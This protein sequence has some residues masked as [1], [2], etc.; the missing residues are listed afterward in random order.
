MFKIAGV[1]PEKGRAKELIEA[2]ELMKQLRDRLAYFQ[3]E[4]ADMKKSISKGI[5]PNTT[6][7]E[8]ESTPES[9]ADIEAEIKDIENKMKV[10][11]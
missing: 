2:S 11:S 3:E 1:D 5:K 6:P 7:N 4:L 8:D 10:A 9:I